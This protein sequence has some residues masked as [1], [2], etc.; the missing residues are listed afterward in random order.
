[1]SSKVCL[2]GMFGDAELYI[3]VNMLTDI[4]YILRKRYT[5]RELQE[6]LSE[7]LSSLKLCGISAEDGTRCL[8][9]G[10][11]DFEDCLVAR[12]AENVKANYII[13]RNKQDFAKSIIPALSPE[14]LF[15]LLREH[16]G[17][18]YEEIEL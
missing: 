9:Q 11:D 13:T 16:N 18:T 1:M 2:L 15:L 5:S 3:T 17:L 7:M 14:E 4:F 8:G 6:L 12:C 10:W